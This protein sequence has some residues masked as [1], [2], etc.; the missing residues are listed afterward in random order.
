MPRD[1]DM[2][3]QVGE[4]IGEL[5]GVREQIAG[6][7]R[8]LER[9]EDESRLSRKGIHEELDRMRV[10]QVNITRSVDAME[11]TLG[12]KD[13]KHDLAFIRTQREF[14]RAAWRHGLLVAIGLLVTGAAAALWLGI[15]EWMHPDR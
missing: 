13:M 5:R 7:R 15:Q 14:Y 2:Q 4:V 9:F 11:K 6:L 3:G 1:G 12:D 8:D 10:S